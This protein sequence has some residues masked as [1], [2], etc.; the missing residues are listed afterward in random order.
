MSARVT[1]YGF[2]KS[3]DTDGETFEFVMGDIYVREFGKWLKA[4]SVDA[5]KTFFNLE[6]L[7]SAKVFSFYTM[8]ESN[9]RWA[10]DKKKQNLNDF[11]QYKKTTKN[12]FTLKIIAMS[13]SFTSI[14]E[15]R[16]CE[17]MN[18]LLGLTPMGTMQSYSIKYKS[19]LIEK[20]ASS[21]GVK[22]GT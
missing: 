18:V 16:D 14:V 10:L 20:L 21:P 15:C 9:A 8:S 7:K 1:F 13:S 19:A 11:F 6:V 12:L 5:R 2:M 17:P 3:M 22:N 4:D